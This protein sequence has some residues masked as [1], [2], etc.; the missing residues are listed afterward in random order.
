VTSVGAYE[1]KTHLAR[2]LEQ[3]ERGETITITKHG[4]EI[5]KLVPVTPPATS[6]D[7]VIAALRAARIGV[8][9][10]RNSV[11]R[12]IDDGRR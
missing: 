3:V 5:A 6:P 12:M 10:G 2:L 7:D 1:A 4:R 11:R 9:R 8:R